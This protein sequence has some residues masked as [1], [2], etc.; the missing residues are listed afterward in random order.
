MI[1]FAPHTKANINRY[2][3]LLSTKLTE[4]ERQYIHELRKNLLR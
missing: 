3:R 1:A 2:C 4:T